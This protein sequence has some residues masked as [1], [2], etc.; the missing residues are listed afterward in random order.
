MNSTSR[1]PISF[2]TLERITE[3]AE[4]IANT[5]E[6]VLMKFAVSVNSMGINAETHPEKWRA[7]QD[8]RQKVNR[9]LTDTVISLEEE[10]KKVMESGGLPE[11]SAT[12]DVKTPLE[13][14][15]SKVILK[16]VKMLPSKISEVSFIRL[17]QLVDPEQMKK[18]KRRSEQSSN[19]FQSGNEY[20]TKFAIAFQKWKKLSVEKFHLFMVSMGVDFIKILMSELGEGTI[21][22]KEKKLKLSSEIILF[23]VMLAQIRAEDIIE[24]FSLRFEKKIL[25]TTRIDYSIIRIDSDTIS[26]DVLANIATYAQWKN[27]ATEKLKHI[28]VNLAIDFLRVVASS[29]DPSSMC[30]SETL[31]PST[32]LKELKQRFLEISKEIWLDLENELLLAYSQMKAAET[33]QTETRL[34]AI[35]IQISPW[36]AT[37]FDAMKKILNNL[38]GAIREQFPK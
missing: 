36:I 13:S 3:L 16:Q 12:K 2:F 28:M 30:S 14:L 15:L 32:D 19:G 1:R 34:T 10:L 20:E 25:R 27:K 6:N 18:L 22:Q 29:D 26:L 4:E 31:N 21:P 33:E 8:W 17:L 7:F 5:L 24:K 23:S 38:E 9:E 11:S 35:R 37:G